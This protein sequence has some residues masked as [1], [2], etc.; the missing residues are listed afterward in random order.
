VIWLVVSTPLK[1]M[2]Q[3]GLLFP[4]YGKA[5]SKPPTSDV[6]SKFNSFLFTPKNGQTPHLY[7]KSVLL[8]SEKPGLCLEPPMHSTAPLLHRA[9]LDPMILRVTD[10]VRLLRGFFSTPGASDMAGGFS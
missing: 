10:G 7:G 1:N 3:L 9:L 6:Y 8:Q 5:C 4:I 2:S